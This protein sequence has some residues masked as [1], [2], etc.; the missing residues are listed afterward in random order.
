MATRRHGQHGALYVDISLLGTGT[1]TLV[2]TLNE[3]TVQFVTDKQEVTAYEDP[4]KVYVSGKPDASGTYKGFLDIASD[5]LYYAATGGQARK[6]YHYVD[7]TNDPNK[8]YFG[9][10]IFDMTV[11]QGVAGGVELSGSWAAASAVFR[12]WA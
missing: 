7:T 6:F 5:Q 9:T 12:T 11:N 2:T 3:H 1:A 10:A 4:N 8:Y